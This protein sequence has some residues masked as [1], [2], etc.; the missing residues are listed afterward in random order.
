MSTNP[1]KLKIAYLYPDILQG[2]CDMANVET[3]CQRA[4]WRDIE[5]S[6]TLVH[7]NDKVQSSKYDFYYIGGTDPDKTSYALKFL[8]QNDDEI[9]IAAISGVPMLAVNSG[10]QLFGNHFQLLD[11]PEAKGI[12]VFDV[13]SNVSSINHCG[14]VIGKSEFLKNKIAGYVNHN[15]MTY[16][17]SEAMPFLTLQKGLG[18][19]ETDKTEGARFNNVIGTYIQGPLLAQNPYLCDFFISMA[20]KVKYKCKIPLTSLCDDLEWYSYKYLMDGKTSLK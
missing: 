3:F 19:N 16:F 10:Y 7:A 15:V 1:L 8:K 11:K 20:L 5:T 13:H 6:V 2:F 9:K 12:G 18:N 4:N 17:D 14:V